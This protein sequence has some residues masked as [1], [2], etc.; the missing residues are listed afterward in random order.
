MDAQWTSKPTARHD[1]SDKIP[2]KRA[3]ADARTRTGDPFITRESAGNFARSGSV[4]NAHE[5]LQIVRRL[6]VRPCCSQIVRGHPDGRSVDVARHPAHEFGASGRSTVRAGCAEPASDK[7]QD[8]TAGACRSCFRD[9][10]G[11][12]PGRAGDRNHREGSL[13]SSATQAIALRE[14]EGVP[15]GGWRGQGDPRRNVGTLPLPRTPGSEIG[16][17]SP[18][19][20]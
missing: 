11:P 19:S 15:V 7:S 3:K 10:A 4:R 12:L 5:S 17:T 1:G 8:A 14:E 6:G 2:A 16:R 18:A 13:R 20:N 9:S